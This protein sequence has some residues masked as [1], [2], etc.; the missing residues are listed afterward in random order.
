MAPLQNVAFEMN[1]E[2]IKAMLQGLEKIRDQ[3]AGVSQ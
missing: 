1:L 3:L 2:E